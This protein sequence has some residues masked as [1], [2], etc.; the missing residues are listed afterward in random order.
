MR[1]ISFIFAAVAL[2]TICAGM[3]VGA[4]FDFSD[5]DE[6]LKKYTFKGTKENIKLSLFNYELLKNDQQFNDLLSKLE[7]FP[8]NTLETRNEKI[9]FWINAYNIMAVKMVADHYPVNSIKDIGNWFNIVW[10]MKAGIIGNKPYSL[11]EIEHGILRKMEDPHIHG[12]IVCASLSC[13]DIAIESYKPETLV[14]QLDNQMTSFLEN[15]TKGFVAYHTEAL[16]YVS[17]IF[18]WFEKDF[19]KNGGVLSCLKKH[20]PS[21][22]RKYVNYLESKDFTLKYIDFNWNL[23]GVD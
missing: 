9:A 7:M 19:N 8:T 20:A 2:L 4:T 3:A 5:W 1:K 14:S 16:V 13:P 10:N 12:A 15:E 17:P 22:K 23:N 6:L 11:N 18:K 21:D